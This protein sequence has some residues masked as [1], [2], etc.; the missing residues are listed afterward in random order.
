MNAKHT[1]IPWKLTPCQK[2]NIASRG[3][4]V[5]DPRDGSRIA[6]V[7]GEQGE[8]L[9]TNARLIAAAPELLAA[10]KNLLVDSQYA[11]ANGYQSEFMLRKSEVAARD[12]I[13]KVRGGAS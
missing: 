8:E 12:A 1:P 11:R 5:D 13:A 9:R 7:F 3:W 4:F 6:F 10:L 2:V